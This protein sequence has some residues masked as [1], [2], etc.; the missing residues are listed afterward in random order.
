MSANLT[1]DPPRDNSRRLSIAIV[2]HLFLILWTLLASAVCSSMEATFALRFAC[3][4]FTIL[5]AW[6]FGSWVWAGGRVM[7]PYALF[8][9]SAL[10]FNG[11]QTWL[12]AIDPTTVLL[13]NEVGPVTVLRT[14]LVVTQSVMFLHLGA[15]L[16]K[17]RTCRA[18]LAAVIEAAK[19]DQIST[20][21]A[22]YWLL[23]I[24][25][26]PAVMTLYSAIQTVIVH[27]YA[28]L[29]ESDQPAGL[30]AAPRLIAT[31]LLPATFM[32]FAGNPSKRLV[33]LF[34]VLTLALFSVAW[35]FLG[36][37]AAAVTALVAFGWLWENCVGK[38][39]RS[40]IIS[41]A[42]SSLFLLPLIG[43]ARN[44][45]GSERS[46][47]T[48]LLDAA[49]RIENPAAALLYEMG[50]SMGTVAHTMELV[51]ALR[52]YDA[53]T[54]YL[55]ASLTALPNI[56]GGPVHPA[57]AHGS[58]SV[59]LVSNVDP[60]GAA[61]GLGLGYSFIAE[62]YANFGWIGDLIVMF[63]FGMGI[64]WMA[65]WVERAPAPSRLAVTASI[66]SFLLVFA[67]SESSD[68]VRG[69]VWYGIVPYGLVRL[70]ALRMK[71]R[72]TA[73]SKDSGLV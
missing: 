21:K 18:S 49:G 13:R 51:P 3:W 61:M 35:L 11:G 50:G 34:C 28:F 27:G 60:V 1:L 9:C 29:Y 48:F 72:G 12:Y 15:L 38:I 55:Y 6:L 24:A 44:I 25:A 37:R 47:L 36:A 68:L 42:L 67:R 58:M 71:S 19:V 53:G 33:R 2:I 22:G 64:Q 73:I 31:M 26:I 59:W 17:R 14:V 32:V 54:S 16:V 45:S 10:V 30:Q 70:T 4:T 66:L 57:A 46:S 8:L 62:S 20:S 40:V 7:S 5:S 65:N 63:A 39:R 43:V 69:I 56:F 23:S 52:P 41:G